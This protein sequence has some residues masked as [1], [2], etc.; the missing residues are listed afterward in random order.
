MER[1]IPIAYQV[2][3]E[4]LLE[5]F[6]TPSDSKPKMVYAD[7]LEEQGDARAEF[8]RLDIELQNRTKESLDYQ[9]LL[10]ARSELLPQIDRDWINLLGKAAIE[11]CDSRANRA[12]RRISGDPST[13]QVV[14]F[15]FRCPK[16][17]ENL[18]PQPHTT[19]M[20]ICAECN[21]GVHYCYTISQA[22][23]HA[24][25]GHCVAV[26]ASV[27]RKLHDLDFVPS[28]ILGMLAEPDDP[29]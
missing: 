27:P 13:S 17:W 6:E 18:S 5:I 10:A 12:N 28:A 1:S 16:R 25:Q 8:L 15:E 4:F 9:E 26:D 19:E 20:R 2:E 23:E 24:R 11:K 29:S 7:W 22:R 14:E 21:K 3:A